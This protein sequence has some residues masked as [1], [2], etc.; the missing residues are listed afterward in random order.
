[1]AYQCWGGGVELFWDFIFCLTEALFHGIKENLISHRF[2]LV[3]DNLFYIPNWSNQIFV[4]IC[5]IKK[6]SHLNKLWLQGFVTC[7]WLLLLF[8]KE[9]LLLMVC[10][11]WKM[12]LPVAKHL[13]GSN[14]LCAD[15]LDWIFSLFQFKLEI[16]TCA[17]CRKEDKNIQSSFLVCL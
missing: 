16:W 10:I 5:L 1:M 6:K 8:W 17:K 3:M 12:V 9:N 14:L 7:I 2:W 15:T 11:Q 4:S 13:I